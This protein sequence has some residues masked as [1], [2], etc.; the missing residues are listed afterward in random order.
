MLTRTQLVTMLQLQD[1]MNKK[2]N[3]EWISA[4][5]AY[6]RAA[7][8]ESVEAM[9]HHGW[10]WW[11]AQHKDLPQLQMELID[12]WHFA[13]SDYL[14]VCGGSIELAADNIEQSLNNIS[15]IKFDG[16]EYDYA[17][18]GLLDNLQ[19]MTGLCA[20]K[21]FEASL[22]MR[23]AQQCELSGSS[24]YQQ[25]VGKNILN[26]FRQDHGYKDGSYVKTWWGKEDN[27]HLVEVLAELNIE[28]ANYSDEL[29]AGLKLR[30]PS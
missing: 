29:Y 17:K 15:P 4:G 27:E 25:Y 7:M 30:Y 12:I 11:K 28:S 24:L 10:K 1:S 16:N 23:I 9:D 20:V 22:F 26:F 21:R 14:I 19:L 18:A 2:V 6:L 13:L 3:P 5:Y 8:I